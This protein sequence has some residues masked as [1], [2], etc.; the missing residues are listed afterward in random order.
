MEIKAKHSSDHNTCS[1]C[2]KPKAHNSCMCPNCRA[3]TDMR[4]ACLAMFSPTSLIEFITTMQREQV[5]TV[6]Q[7]LNLAQSRNAYQLT[8]LAKK[9]RQYE[10]SNNNHNMFPR[11]VESLQQVSD[12]T[13]KQNK[14]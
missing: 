2:T 8:S 7:L 9:L 1:L 6:A 12:W 5:G 10:R 14:I 13:S 11:L 4:N 3:F